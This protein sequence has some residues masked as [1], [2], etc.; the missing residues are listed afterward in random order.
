MS[1]RRT[2]S[3]IS[4]QHLF[5]DVDAVVFV[6]GGENCYSKEQIDND[7]YNEKSLDVLFWKEIFLEFQKPNLNLK[8]KAVGSKLTVKLIA[9]DIYKSNL[10]KVYAAM[11]RDLDHVQG[12]LIKHK[13]VLYT[14][15]Y[16]WENDAW[17][18]ELIADIIQT[19]TAEKIDETIIKDA[20]LEF[21]KNIKFGVFLDSYLLT[22]NDS[23]FDRNNR[24]LKCLDLDNND[25][26]KVDKEKL[27]EMISEKNVSKST[28]YRFAKKNK[29]NSK[30]DC[31]GHLLADFCYHLIKLLLKKEFGLRV[32]SK[33]ICKR[34][35]LFRFLNYQKNEIKNYYTNCFA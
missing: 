28:I 35:A 27:N 7:L 12:N 21:H 23:L 11:D 6:E 9:Q 3:G 26:L 24:H 10:V 33:E 31:Y 22:K 18:S 29:L 4:N 17:N 15:G 19:I 25:F 5:Y 1:F 34:I 8:Y 13:N 16:S 32:P 14:F 2:N 30:R 20:Y